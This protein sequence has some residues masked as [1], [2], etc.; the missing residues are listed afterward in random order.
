MTTKFFEA[1]GVEKPVLCVRSDEACLA[2]TM[3]KTNAGLA[4]T[5][6]AGIRT[7]ILEKYAEWKHNGFTRQTVNMA[8]KKQFCRE[9]QAQQ[10]TE[11]LDKICHEK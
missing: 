9:Q 2:E 3:Q 8:E 7:F 1:L 10:F 6:T 5:D 11:L 4:A